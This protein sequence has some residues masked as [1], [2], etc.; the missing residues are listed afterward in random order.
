MARGFV[1]WYVKVLR[2]QRALEPR[3]ETDQSRISCV[4]TPDLSFSM[5]SKPTSTWSND[6]SICITRHMSVVLFQRGD[7]QPGPSVRSDVRRPTPRRSAGGG[8]SAGAGGD[9]ELDG[10]GLGQKL[11]V[12]RS[13]SF[14]VRSVCDAL[15][16][17]RVAPF[18]SRPNAP[19]GSRG[20]EPVRSFLLLVLV[21]KLWFGD[22]VLFLFT[23][24]SYPTNR[25]Q[26]K[27]LKCCQ[28]NRFATLNS[29]SS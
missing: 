20:Q 17:A 23:F 28:W 21:K 22:F 2:E 27:V 3:F 4:W 25:I 1:N 15:A 6:P 9:L 8:L 24:R 13:R 29:S 18:G 16:P 11:I 26:R 5:G 14:R 19:F 7:V 10:R 12:E